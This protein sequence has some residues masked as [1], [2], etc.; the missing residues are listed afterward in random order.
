MTTFHTTTDEFYEC[1][2]CNIR[3]DYY[4]ELK[5]YSEDSGGFCPHCG[6][7][8]LKVMTSYIVYQQVWATDEVDAANTAMELD[9]W[10]TVTSSIGP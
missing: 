10:E 9:E 1:R 4:H 8:D 7:D 2:Q 5:H 3:T 6:S